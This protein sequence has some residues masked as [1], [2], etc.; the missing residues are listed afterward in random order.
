MKL[1]FSK[2]PSGTHRKLRMSDQN[3]LLDANIISEVI[4]NAPSFSVIKKLTEHS[5]DCCMSVFTLHELLYGA[6][7][8][9]ESR[10]KTEL[11]KFINDDV[12]DNFPVIGY[13]EADARMHAE[14]RAVLERKGVLLPY[15]DSQIAA[16]AVTNALT[17]VTRNEKHFKPL[18]D[19]FGLKLENWFADKA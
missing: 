5:S 17:L 10:W 9:P 16:I 6:E 7:R 8:L 15:G 19:E 13:S 11:L 14:M 18:K 4:K 1:P 12:C 3:Y 2:T